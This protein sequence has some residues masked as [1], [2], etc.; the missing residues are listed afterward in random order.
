MR[1]TKSYGYTRKING[2]DTYFDIK[3]SCHGVVGVLFPFLNCDSE[4]FPSLEKDALLPSTSQ[5]ELDKILDL[6][7]ALAKRIASGD[8][9]VRS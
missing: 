9:R 4:S 2:R 7:E 5:R 1:K 8:T 3:S 6:Y